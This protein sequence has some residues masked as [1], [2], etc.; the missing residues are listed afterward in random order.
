MFVKDEGSATLL[1]EYTERAHPV[2]SRE[3]FAR[4]PPP[5]SVPVTFPRFLGAPRRGDLPLRHLQTPFPVPHR[6]PYA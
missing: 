1:H 3:P 5:R 6:V 4:I 2:K